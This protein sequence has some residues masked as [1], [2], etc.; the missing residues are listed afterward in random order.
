MPSTKPDFMP[1]IINHIHQDNYLKKM[2]EKEESQMKKKKHIFKDAKQ[3][4]SFGLRLKALDTFK[5]AYDEQFKSFQ[6]MT[7]N[8]T[9]QAQNISPV[10]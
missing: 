9:V 10:K 4:K 1:D 6:R 3:T 7:N 2:K 5:K 8:R